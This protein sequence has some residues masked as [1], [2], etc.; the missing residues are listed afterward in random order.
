M[1][2]FRNGAVLCVVLALTGCSLMEARE[3]TVPVPPGAEE[4]GAYVERTTDMPIP[5]YE[6]APTVYNGD[7]YVFG[8]FR[9]LQYVATQVDIFDPESG[10]WTQGPESPFG[11]THFGGI[12]HKDRIWFVGGF[13]GDNPGKATAT[14]RWFAPETGEY[15]EGPPLPSPRAGGG[16]VLL[17]GKLHAIAGL[18]PDRDTDLNEHL[19]LDLE[20]PVTWT[21]RAPI[22]SPRNH[23]S[24]A[25]VEGK[26][27]TI[28]G[29]FHHDRWD[30]GPFEDVDLVEIYD[31]ATNSWTNGTPCPAKMSHGEPGTFVVNE[32]IVIAGGR[33]NLDDTAAIHA[34][35]TREDRWIA[36]PPL[37][38][39]LK[40][41]VVRILGDRVY[42]FGG[43][44]ARLDPLSE[45]W[46]A[47]LTHQWRDV[48]KARSPVAVVQ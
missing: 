3:I 31:P 1:N 32:W 46:T 25:A 23:F 38:K 2:E 35:N 42:C 7:L 37:P 30:L 36:L 29:T 26:I 21:E 33:E 5:R 13:E 47:P 39:A 9:E 22:P 12:P 16:V 4:D 20:E 17:D 40:A 43:R 8:G 27:Y 24:A 15:G 19:V 11:L 18:M 10:N 14:V 45:A 6:S 28:A 41:P 44:I 48:L 34:Y